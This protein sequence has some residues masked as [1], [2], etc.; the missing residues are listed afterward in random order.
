MSRLRSRCPPAAND[1]RRRRLVQPGHRPAAWQA[2]QRRAVGAW[3]KARWQAE[4]VGGALSAPGAPRCRKAPAPVRESGA[5]RWWRWCPS[6]GKKLAAVRHRQGV[7]GLH[8][9][10][11]DVALWRSRKALGRRRKAFARRWRACTEASR[12][13]VPGNSARKRRKALIM[14]KQALLAGCRGKR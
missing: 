9:G 3:R 10:S 2:H 1:R 7:I 8:G 14:A 11:A 6:A 12:G 5:Q 13:Q 4:R